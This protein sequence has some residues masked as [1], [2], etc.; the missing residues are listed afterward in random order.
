MAPVLAEG[1]EGRTPVEG[2]LYR[3]IVQ[4]SPECGKHELLTQ[5]GPVEL[6]ATSAATVRCDAEVVN[7][8]AQYDA[9]AE[10]VQEA[11]V[12]RALEN[13]SGGNINLEDAAPALGGAAPT[14]ETLK[15]RDIDT[16]KWLRELVLARDGFRCRCCG[17]QV[18]LMGH[19][20]EWLSD[21]GRTEAG[22]LHTL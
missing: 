3:L 20:I 2:S 22:N 1:G 16:P 5:D 15:E 7:V 21:G 18:S 13:A 11:V 12:K 10:R 17:Y 14:A 19:H 8:A 6:D 9:I 4:A